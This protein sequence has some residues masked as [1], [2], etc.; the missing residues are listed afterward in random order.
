MTLRIFL[1]G[2]HSLILMALITM[3]R[4]W[5]KHYKSMNYKP[6]LS[7][8][9]KASAVSSCT[10]TISYGMNNKL[11]RTFQRFTKS[12]L[13]S[14]MQS[15]NNDIDTGSNYIYVPMEELLIDVKDQPITIKSPTNL[16]NRY[17]GLRHGESEANMEGIISSNPEV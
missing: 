15:N 12:S 4:S 10:V 6:N 1:Q 8:V 11:N 2:W 3:C 14:T 7:V 13:F 9:L 17:F 5:S 16:K